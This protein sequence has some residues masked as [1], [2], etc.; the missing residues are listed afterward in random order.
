MAKRST[1]KPQEELKKGTREDVTAPPV[2][3]AIPPG[4]APESSTGKRS[5]IRRDPH[6]VTVNSPDVDHL[7]VERI[8]EKYEYERTV[9]IIEEEKLWR[10]IRSRRIVFDHYHNFIN[11]I[12]T[13]KPGYFRYTPTDKRNEESDWIL[14]EEQK[15]IRKQSKIEAFKRNGTIEVDPIKIP[16]V[17]IQSSQAY[18]ILQYATE[19]YVRTV[20][21]SG[22]DQFN[23][24]TISNLNFSPYFRLIDRKISTLSEE[25]ALSRKTHPVLIELIWSYWQEEGY[26]AQTMNAISRRFQNIKTGLSN[27]L[28][29]LDIDPLRPL[30]NILWGYIQNTQNRLTIPRRAYEY[31]HHYGISILGKAIPNFNPVDSRSGF[32]GAFNN[33]LH[34]AALFFRD[35]DDLNRRADAFSLLNALKEVHMLLAE[36]AHNQF[37]DLPTTAKVEM[38]ME[39]WIL[40]RPE[41]REFLGGKIMIPHNEPWMER[42][43]AMKNLQG[44]DKT[45]VNYYNDLAIFGEQL[46]LTIRYT[47]WNLINESTFAASWAIQ[48]RN[49]IQ[50]YIYRYHVVTGLDLSADAPDHVKKEFYMRPALLIKR[51]LN[52]NLN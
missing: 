21:D 23:P 5:D 48:W 52:K 3:T 10:L 36:G 39:Q 27:S 40:S 26:L 37:G 31:E 24:E 19:R 20:T 8:P 51:K 18:Y 47:N 9:D 43:D 15:E 29:Q 2:T 41:V 22:D 11:E 12:M 33:L 30:G 35:H 50:G 17:P 38:L 13:F 45:G 44:W 25:G 4:E 6:Q 7:R 34:K 16:Q 46:I 14:D 1:N 49:E 42:V 28:T 32:I